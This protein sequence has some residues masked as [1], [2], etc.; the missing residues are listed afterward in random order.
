M[1]VTFLAFV[2]VVSISKTASGR[3]SDSVAIDCKRGSKSKEQRRK[4]RRVK[5]RKWESECQSEWVYNNDTVSSFKL[6]QC[7]LHTEFGRS[8]SGIPSSTNSKYA[9]NQRINR[10]PGISQRVQQLT[11][12]SR[13]QMIGISSL[14]KAV[15]RQ[16]SL[17][18]F[19]ALYETGMHQKWSLVP[20]SKTSP[21]S[22]WPSTTQISVFNV[23]GPLHTHSTHNML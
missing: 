1:D 11:M 5:N 20:F 16:K 18:H 13:H 17:F 2:C 4:S 7:R 3:D 21:P 6:T 22:H 10:D 12:C 8:S 15:T 9:Q 19:Q 14:Q 23:D